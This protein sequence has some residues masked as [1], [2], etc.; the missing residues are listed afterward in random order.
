MSMIETT[1]IR[2]DS[3]Q[4]ILARLVRNAEEGLTDDLT[5]WQTSYVGASNLWR[6][7]L[8]NASTWKDWCA[9]LPA[10]PK[11]EHDNLFDKADQDRT[12]VSR[13]SVPDEV[14]KAFES[15]YGSRYLHCDPAL[16]QKKATLDKASS[17]ILAGPKG[18]GKTTAMAYL[19]RTLAERACMGIEH[20]LRRASLFAFWRSAG[21]F[22]ALHNGGS[23]DNQD[24]R[25]FFVDD[26]GREYVEPFALAQMEE[27]VEYR[28]GRELPIVMT[29]NL[30]WKDFKERVGF[31]RITD[32]LL[33]MA[34]WINFTGESMRQK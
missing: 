29:T 19:A 10:C 11:W 31:E 5:Q 7:K 9:L 2:K 33:E 3:T 18:T 14:M 23:I 4:E 21:I 15:V 20:S 12:L 28:Y 16:I 22:T 17:V 26:F 27:F 34:S 8:T 30:S 24:A 1:E 32:R 25:Y 6:V 13:A